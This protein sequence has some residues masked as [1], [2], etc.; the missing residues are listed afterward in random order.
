[1]T[2]K[3]GIDQFLSQ[4]KLAVV[5][6]SRNG[7]KFGNYAGKELRSKGYQVIPV[8]PEAEVI[9]GE[10]CFRSLS[11]I[12]DG[13]GGVFIAVK[14]VETE[15]VV[16]EVAEAGIKHVWIQQGAESTAAVDFCIEQELNV[17]HGECIM[18]FAEPVGSIHG[19]HRWLWKLFGKL[20]N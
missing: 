5:G 15:K 11:E 3:A 4:K 19:F 6:A 20:P 17:I 9:D 2:T 1:M 18:M 10:N 12:P 7:K 8:H 16:R 14:P 13:V